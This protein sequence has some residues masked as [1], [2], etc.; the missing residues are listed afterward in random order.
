MSSQPRTLTLF[1]YLHFAC[2]VFD[3]ERTGLKEEAFVLGMT[4]MI[5]RVVIH[6]GNPD[7]G[8]GFSLTFSDEPFA[9]HDAELRWLRSDPAGHVHFHRVSLLTNEAAEASIRGLSCLFIDGVASVS[10]AVAAILATHAGG[11][12]SL[13]GPK[14]ASPRAIAVLKAT[15]S[16]ELAATLFGSSPTP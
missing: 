4:E 2:W 12:L 10:S 1:P 13:R 15:P 9:G 5:T 3:D 11:T 14:E 6:K 7:G 16:V 8:R